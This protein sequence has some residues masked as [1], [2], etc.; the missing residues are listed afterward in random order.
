LALLQYHHNK[1]VSC[2]G[3]RSAAGSINGSNSKIIKDRKKEENKGYGLFSGTIIHNSLIDFVVSFNHHVTGVPCPD[4][5][6]IFP[7]VEP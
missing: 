6:L 4:T 5:I 2:R 1:R 3:I 7:T